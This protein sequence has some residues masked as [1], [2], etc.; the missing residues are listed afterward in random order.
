MHFKPTYWSC[1][2]VL[3]IVLCNCELADDGA[4]MPARFRSDI[5]EVSAFVGSHCNSCVTMHRM[6]NV[7]YCF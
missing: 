1:Q 6:K 5:N 3:T 7:K 2:K 4:V